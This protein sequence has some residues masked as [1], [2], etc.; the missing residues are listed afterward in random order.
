MRLC[1]LRLT[2]Q[3]GLLVAARCYPAKP[4]SARL[5]KK[6]GA[7]VFS[8]H[9]PFNEILRL[10]VKGGKPVARVRDR[11][12]HNKS[13]RWRMAKNM[14]LVSF[15][16]TMEEVVDALSDC[17]F[18]V[19]RLKEPRPAAFARKYNPQAYA[20]TALY[21]TFCVIKARKSR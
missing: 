17:G 14:R 1:A 18:T 2:D 6:G 16:H 8:F 15:H 7:F 4:E 11:Y 12:F 19:E 3:N 9:H 10:K 5:L 21:P 20:L 13:Y